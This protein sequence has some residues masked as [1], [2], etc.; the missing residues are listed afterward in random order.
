MTPLPLTARPRPDRTRINVAAYTL[1]ELGWGFAWSLTFEAPMVAAFARGVGH[2]DADVGNIWLLQGLGLSLPMLLTAWLLAPLGRM[3]GLVGWGHAIAALLV[4]GL[5]VV[6]AVGDAPTLR[7]AYLLTVPVFFVVIG[8]QI[9]AWYALVGELFPAATQP[10][11]LGF[12]FAINR[13][14]ALLGGGVAG[15]VLARAASPREAWTVLFAISGGA[16]LLA[17]LA[18]LLIRETGVRPRPRP[19]LKRYLAGLGRTWRR[20]AAY[21]RFVV[22]DAL[23][24][25]QFIVIALFADAAFARDGHPRSWAGAWT[26]AGA[27]GMMAACVAVLIVGRRLTPRTWLLFGMSGLAGG[28]ILAVFGGSTGRYTIVAVTVGWSLGIRMVCLGP[29]LMRLVPARART[30]A[31]GLQGALATALQGLFAFAGGRLASALG[32]PIV[33]GVAAGLILLSVLLLGVWV[34]RPGRL[35]GPRPPQA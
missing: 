29:S 27:A 4:S 35:V 32:Y 26:Q 21:R 15:V 1:S 25:A 28:G 33:F 6:A 19:P 34:P 22:A 18:Y 12:V 9:P 14:G 11:L 20:W 23:G 31:L 2:G 16:G 10:R 8:V 7:L 5:A 13:V 17:S 30:R 24:I 3:R